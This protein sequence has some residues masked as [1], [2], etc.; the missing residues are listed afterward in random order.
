MS[1]PNAER[2]LVCSI[3]VGA[4]ASGVPGP[5]PVPSPRELSDDL[6]RE[7]RETNKLLRE[8]VRISHETLELTKINESRQK[9]QIDGQRDEFIRWLSEYPDL[10]GRCHA[11]HEVIRRLLGQSLDELVAY[12]DEHHDSLGESEFAR[13][14]M[15]DRF[16][17]LL[18]H[19]SSMY[20]VVKRVCSADQ[21]DE[22]PS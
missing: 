12:I 19:A 7:L 15:I 22:S 11:A 21:P 1:D 5:A 20:G 2:N 16:G 9:A 10:R 6:V 4:G 3:D 14:E 8:M 18:N 13:N 17:S